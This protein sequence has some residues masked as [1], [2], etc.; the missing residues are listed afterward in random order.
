SGTRMWPHCSRKLSEISESKD[1][2]CS[3]FRCCRVRERVWR[4]DSVSWNSDEAP[5][6]SLSATPIWCSNF[7]AA[8]MSPADQPN[9]IAS[10][11]H[12]M[13]SSKETTLSGEDSKI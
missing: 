5:P 3:A 9:D 6:E 10:W 12:A 7:K 4:N 1:V 8:T 2:A 11:A 13:D